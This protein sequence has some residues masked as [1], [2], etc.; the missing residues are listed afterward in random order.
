MYSKPTEIQFHIIAWR[1]KIDTTK[2]YNYL[3]LKIS[4]NGK[5]DF[6]FLYILISCM[7]RVI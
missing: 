4:K 7:L 1:Q 6:I 3:G 2:E 5:F